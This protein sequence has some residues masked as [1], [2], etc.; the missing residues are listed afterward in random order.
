MTII[1]LAVLIAG[2]IGMVGL[3]H[4]CETLIAVED[5]SM[6]APARNGQQDEPANS[7]GIVS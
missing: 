4:F 3:V 1:M 2:F 5:S 6:Q 7:V